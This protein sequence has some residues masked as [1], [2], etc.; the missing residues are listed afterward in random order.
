MGITKKYYKDTVIEAFEKISKHFS[1]DIIEASIDYNGED[2]S[3][4]RF[5]WNGTNKQWIKQNGLVVYESAWIP[6]GKGIKCENCQRHFAKTFNE[7]KFCP[8]CGGKCQ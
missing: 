3:V 1:N 7:Y 2:D 4:W 5:V 8:H 6:D